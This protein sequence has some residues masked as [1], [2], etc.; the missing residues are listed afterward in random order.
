MDP[1]GLT[2]SKVVLSEQELTDKRFAY[3][4]ILEV[5]NF[6]G[7]K[8][9][10]SLEDTPMVIT[11]SD[12]KGYI[13]EMIGNEVMISNMSQ[14]SVK[15]GVKFTQEDMGTNVISLTLQQNHPV[16]LIGPNHYHTFLHN[17]A[18]Y[19]VP[20][21]YTNDN[22]L[23]GSICIMTAIV[24]HNPF[25]LMMLDTVVDSIER[26]LLL[27]K[28]NR[29]LNILNQKLNILNQIMLSKTKNAIFIT[30]ADGKVTEFNAFA[31]KIF[32]FKKEEIIGKSI[33]NSKITGDFLKN[34]LNFGK[35]YENI[36]IK[37]KNNNNENYI[38]LFDT[39]P[40]HDE[41]LKVIGAF[42]Q[43]RDI[44]DRYLAE[45]K[46]KNTEKEMS[47]LDRL[48][49]IGQTAAG[50]GHEVRNPMTTVRGFLQLLGSK[51][52][53]FKYN[54]YFTLMIDELDRANEIITEFLSLAK[55]RVVDLKVQSLKEIVQNI[56]PLIQADGLV[57]DKYI[58]MGLEEVSEIPLDKKEIHQLILNLVLNGS[59]A[60][61]PGGTMKIRTFMVNEEIVLAVQDDGKGIAEEV[62]GKI[63][64][65]FF[66]TKEN[67]TGLGL[68]VCY[69]IAARHNAKIDIETGPTG[70]TFLVRFKK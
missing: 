8:I 22:N 30:N 10:K 38:C 56:F 9:L 43:F 21:H 47:R 2:F 70:T 66:T 60:M 24:L 4:E 19:G 36:E 32:G 51:E 63:G 34:V 20:F 40:I 67:G 44:T 55:D 52:E 58:H 13:L 57:S 48:N 59:Q 12:E 39:Q 11:I 42:G 6:F 1:N 35:I 25:F 15:P 14:L 69:S 17:S 37:F 49:L 68:A 3:E 28:Q 29:K 62:L 26:E 53:C 31:E 61:S 65:P 64:T 41:N 18:C 27:R 33:F 50:I 5:V 54:D 46:Y 7:K 45:E 23:I 16:Q